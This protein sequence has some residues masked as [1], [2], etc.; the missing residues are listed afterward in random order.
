MN[1]KT[2]FDKRNLQTNDKLRFIRRDLPFICNE[3][4][5]GIEV[6]TSPLTR[7]GY[8]MDLRIFFRFLTEE[9]AEFHG[10]NVRRIDHETLAKITSTHIELFMDYLTHYF[11][12]DKEYS[13]TL[14]TKARKLSSIKAFFKYEY[15]KDRIPSDPAAKVLTPKLHDKAIVR[16][17][18]DEVGKL[19]DEA[20]YGNEL[21]SREYAFHKLTQ[22]R[23]VAI[24]TLFLG[25][26]I[27]ISELVG[28]D[29]NDVDFGVN[30]FK[31]TRKGG[32]QTIL[33]FSDEV[34][35]AL[36]DYLDERAQNEALDHEAAFFVSLQNKR[37]SVRAV[38]NLV[39]KY[40]Q[41]VTPLKNITP[42]KLRS[43]YGTNLYQ[44]THDIYVVAE[45]LGHKDI[46]TTKKHYAAI[47]DDTKR[48]A[49]KQ[50][51]LRDKKQD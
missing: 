9:I 4:F 36:A 24:L 11:I 48:N 1:D 45:V 26:G 22:K 30:G 12:D 38:Q 10:L 6:R 46:N 44:E 39:K 2:Y 18:V 20:E 47:S 43:T 32:N 21:T 16:L 25:T 5:V 31:I 51:V 14:T 13:N 3:F 27:R 19:L 33:Y 7:L 8:A 17:E 29:L 23:D 41:K 50:I 15:N 35:L 42:H 40:A 28:L 34:A 49:A 37:I